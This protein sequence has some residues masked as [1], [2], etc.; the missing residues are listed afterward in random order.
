[1]STPILEP[2]EAGLT[3]ALRNRYII[4]HHALWGYLHGAKEVEKAKQP[5]EDASS[6]T[7]SVNDA[8]VRV[9]H[10]R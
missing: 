2:I 5:Q 3:V 4:K 9:R 10:T 7:T 8:E 1:M 6:T